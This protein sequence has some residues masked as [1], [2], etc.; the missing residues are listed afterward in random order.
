MGGRC[1]LSS[2][3]RF[4]I[5][6]ARALWCATESSFR[7]P[8]LEPALPKVGCGLVLN[9]AS[10]SILARCACGLVCTAALQHC[11]TQRCC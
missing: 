7:A 10:Q 9:A 2:A 8:R 4:R 6:A 1:V 3:R 11:Q 5:A